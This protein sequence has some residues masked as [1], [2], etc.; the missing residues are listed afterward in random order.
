MQNANVRT[1]AVKV[2][3]YRDFSQPNEDSFRHLETMLQREVFWC[4][5]PKTLNDPE[6]FSWK[7][8]Y[9]PSAATAELLANLLVRV[10]GRTRGQALERAAAAVSSGR[11][12]VLAKPIFNNMIQHCRNEIGLACFGT[13]PD[14]S[15]LWQRYGG[16]GAGICV[17][18]DVPAALLEE[19]LFRVQYSSAKSIHIDQLIRAFV[20]P[21]YVREVYAL[22]LLSKPIAWA[23]EEEIR[24]VSR[25]QEVLVQIDGSKITRL[26]LGDALTPVVRGRIEGIAAALR[27]DL[28]TY[29]YVA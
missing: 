4:A 1:Q 15:C 10:N 6:E 27:R 22:A 13:S 14:N 24:F 12:E 5:R 20:E 2:Y 8:D 16:D 7:C 21:G 18:M 29:E 19:Q 23:T 3:K 11:L 25:K 28:Q 9:S 26:I 17:E